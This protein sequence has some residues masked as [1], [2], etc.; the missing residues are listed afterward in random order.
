MCNSMASVLA[1]CMSSL[2]YGRPPSTDPR[3][4][5]TSVDLQGGK[6]VPLHDM[7]CHFDPNG[8]DNLRCSIFEQGRS[9]PIL[10]HHAS[11]GKL[12]RERTHTFFS[13]L[14]YSLSR[15]SNHYPVP[16]TNV[17]VKAVTVTHL[18]PLEESPMFS[19]GTGRR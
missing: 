10:Q 16:V 13:W 5:G 4:C 11:A 15:H 6:L 14:E 2:L 8:S 19:P 3:M 1:A 12:R 17:R 7:F 18:G 9:D